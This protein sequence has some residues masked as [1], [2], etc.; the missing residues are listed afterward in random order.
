M[1]DINKI[2][3]EDVKNSILEKFLIAIQTDDVKTVKKLF[4]DPISLIQIREKFF[5]DNYINY[6][7]VAKGNLDMIKIVYQ[8]CLTQKDFLTYCCSTAV[9]KQYVDIV[10]F[11]ID[12]NVQVNWQQLLPRIVNKDNGNVEILQL[13][14]DYSDESKQ[15]IPQFRPGIDPF[16][17][18]ISSG[19]FDIVKLLINTQ[20]KLYLSHIEIDKV[21]D[22]NN[23]KSNDI[24]KYLIDYQLTHNIFL[25]TKVFDKI[26]HLALQCFSQLH[27]K[28][29][30]NKFIFGE[31]E[32]LLL[33]CAKSGNIEIIQH[34]AEK[35]AINKSVLKNIIDAHGNETSKSFLKSY[36]LNE[37]LNHELDRNIDKEATPHTTKRNK[38]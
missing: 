14:I 28:L 22:N 3:N 16:Y 7:V 29:K 34:L 30:I 33:T 32:S 13:L 18:A 4:E 23:A 15:Q 11:C 5:S 8:Y 38:I 27:D 10:Q 1:T 26:K 20:K 12:Q 24:L 9:E 25:S 19:H 17:R 36:K 37:K 21:A 31:Y 35:K 2:V 6:E